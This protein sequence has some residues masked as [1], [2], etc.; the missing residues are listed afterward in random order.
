MY[1]W[2]AVFLSYLYIVVSVRVLIRLTPTQDI[3]FQFFSQCNF[4]SPAQL[5]GTEL[6]VCL[7]ERRIWASNAPLKTFSE[8]NSKILVRVYPNTQLPATTFQEQHIPRLPVEFKTS[9]TIT[10]AFPSGVKS[11]ILF[12]LIKNRSGAAILRVENRCYACE[13]PFCL[14]IFSESFTFS[15]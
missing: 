11:S 12:L 1:H 5:L 6:I 15:R 10:L 4:R 2:V 7:K 9:T 3:F 14:D 13:M 8:A